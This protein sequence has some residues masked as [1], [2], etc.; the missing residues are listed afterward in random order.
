MH[1]LKGKGLL[2]LDRGVHMCQEEERATKPHIPLQEVAC[3][4]PPTLE[5][6]PKSLEKQNS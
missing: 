2:G 3:S 5:F 1:F 4:P 6:F